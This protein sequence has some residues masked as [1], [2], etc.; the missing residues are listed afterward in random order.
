MELVAL[1]PKEANEVL[2][3]KHSGLQ[4]ASPSQCGAHEDLLLHPWELCLQ[5]RG[6]TG[7]SALHWTWPKCFT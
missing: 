2:L 6:F 5:L 7:H 1:N 4:A 3:E